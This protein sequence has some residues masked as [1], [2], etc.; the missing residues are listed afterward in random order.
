MSTVPINRQR[1]TPLPAD[2]A[3]KLPCNLD[4]ERSVLGA[5]LLN[6]AA[7]KEIAGYLKV[8]DFFLPQHRHIFDMMLKLAIQRIQQNNALEGIDLVTLTEELARKELLESSG[9]APYLAA[10]VDGVPRVSNVKHYADILIRKSRMRQL[11]HVTHNIQQRA[12][13]EQDDPDDVLN[14]AQVSLTALEAPR[15]DQNPAVVV[16][17]QSLLTRECPPIEHAIEPLLTKR[18]TGEIYS[19]RGY[20]KSLICTHMAMEIAMGADM[21]WGGHKGGGGHW[22]VHRAFRQ[23]YVYGEMTDSEIQDRIRMLARMRGSET[24]SDEQLGTMCMDYQ[25]GW[26]P[27]ISSARDRKFIEDRLFGCAYEG[28]WLDNLSTLWPASQEGESERDAILAEWF[29]DLNQRGIWVIYLH[30]AGKGGEQRGGSQKEDMLSFVIKFRHPANYKPEE[31]LRVEAHIEKNRHK[32]LSPATLMPFEIQ[33]VKNAMAQPEWVTRPAQ[34]AQRAAAFE[35]FK[36]GMPT[37]LVGQEVGVSRA[38]AYRW[39]KD[40]DENPNP[41][42]HLTPED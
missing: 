25:K 30:H 23:L 14:S 7:I 32:C 40:F 26:R 11:I 15:G 9:G 4:A 6:N 39:K 2:I 20:G 34:A 18:G 31:R 10:L 38:T 42:F 8:D 37:M 5:I 35:M 41:D 33:L 21:L 28:L 36:N 19:W 17:F 13:E 3:K 24:P 27:K 1:Q 12:W 16:G 22:S 29:T